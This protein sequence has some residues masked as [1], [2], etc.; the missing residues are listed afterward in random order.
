MQGQNVFRRQIFNHH[1]PL[2]WQETEV[3]AIKFLMTLSFM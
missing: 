1:I 2:N 3:I